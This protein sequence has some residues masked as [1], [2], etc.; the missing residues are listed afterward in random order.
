MPPRVILLAVKGGLRGR[1]FE[2]CGQTQCVVG[3]S[4]DC[5]LRLPAEDMTT[6]RHHCLLEI[7][8]P[9]LTLYDL[10]STNGTLVNGEVVPPLR[11]SADGSR[12]APGRALEVGDEI[13]LGG[14]VLRVW[15]VD[16]PEAAAGEPVGAPVPAQVESTAGLCQTCC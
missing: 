2:F 13:R 8:A 12:A 10:G 5:D 6:S 9:A 7:A 14:T 3:R 11:Q 4:R 1:E 15:I 16:P